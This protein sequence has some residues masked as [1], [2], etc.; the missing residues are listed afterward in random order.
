MIPDMTKPNT[1]EAYS[2]LRLAVK[3]MHAGVP[4]N[5][6]RL[7]R[8]VDMLRPLVRRQAKLVNKIAKH[9]KSDEQNNI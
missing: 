9:R 6:D 4:V 5:V 7:E 1:I 8:A 2:V 3:D